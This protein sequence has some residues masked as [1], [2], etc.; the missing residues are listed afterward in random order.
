MSRPNFL[1]HVW[2]VAIVAAFQQRKLAA[3]CMKCTC[4]FSLVSP[5]QKQPNERLRA[6]VRL[7]AV[8]TGWHN[9][10]SGKSAPLPALL[11]AQ[12]ASSSLAQC[13]PPLVM[14]V[15]RA[16]ERYCGMLPVQCA[17]RAQSPISSIAPQ[18]IGGGG[19]CCYCFCFYSSSS[20]NV[21]W[22]ESR[23]LGGLLQSRVGR[24]AAP[25]E[26]DASAPLCKR[27]RRGGG[28]GR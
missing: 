15:Q 10:P 3:D 24:P 11:S 20:A 9:R 26:P 12:S 13:W 28:R 27:A 4:C 19:G 1:A 5:V 6:S 25:G 22:Q 23:P 7:P 14:S 2:L 16:S 18:P 17:S 8:G 21:D